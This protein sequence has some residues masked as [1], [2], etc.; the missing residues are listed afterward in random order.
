M[1]W[2][3]ERKFATNVLVPRDLRREARSS[4][5]LAAGAAAPIEFVLDDLAAQRIAVDAEHDCGSGLIAL[6]AI[7]YALDEA[8]LELADSLVKQNA[9][10]HHLINKTFQLIL[11]VNVLQRSGTCFGPP[12]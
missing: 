9:V 12:C 6:D 5:Q 2:P 11:H 3:Y 1:P 7:E 4:A 10:F 8:L